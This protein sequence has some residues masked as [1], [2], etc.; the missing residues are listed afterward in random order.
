MIRKFVLISLLCLPFVTGCGFLKQW[1]GLDGNSSNNVPSD[2]QTAAQQCNGDACADVVE[3]QSKQVPT[4]CPQCREFVNIGT[5]PIMLDWTVAPLGYFSQCSATSHTK[6][7]RHNDRVGYMQALCPPYGANYIPNASSNSQ[8]G[9]SEARLLRVSTSPQSTAGTGDEDSTG[10]LKAIAV[11][12]PVI[13]S[14][15]T[16]TITVSLSA[17]SLTERHVWLRALS[18]TEN[19]DS[20]ASFP[21]AIKI[22]QGQ[23]TIAVSVPSHKI[24]TALEITLAAVDD[25]SSVSTTIRVT[26]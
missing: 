20:F 1:S 18:T 17:A 11:N 21:V 6:L 16:I 10:F 8:R 5:K 3:R 23:S 15:S 26:P 2:G 24:T 19:V 22:P 7:L 9:A 13:A 4:P 12:S 14:G 25:Q